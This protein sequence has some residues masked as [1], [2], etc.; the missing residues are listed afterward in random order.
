MI[1][2]NT[3]LVNLNHL[4]LIQIEG[5]ECRKFLQGQLTCD[6]QTLSSEHFTHG[7]H[8]TPKGR[9]IANF[10]AFAL[11]TEAIVLRAPAE[12]LPALLASLK[13]YIVFSKATIADISA[14]YTLVGV[15]GESID[16]VLQELQLNLAEK[17]SA[18]TNDIIFH[19]LDRTR[20]EC[21]IPTS[22]K[23]PEALQ[24]LQ[25]ADTT[26]HWQARDIELGRGWVQQETIEEFL[27]QMLN[28]QT[29]AIQGINFKK[30]CYTG[31]EI[32]AR[33]HYKGKLKR[34]MYRFRCSA[35]SSLNA[36][37]NL[38]QVDRTQPA[39]QVINSVYIDGHCEL[40]ALAPAVQSDSGTDLLV[41]ENS[42]KLE[43]IELPYAITT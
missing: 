39:G 31:Q 35:P 32:V 34:H 7:A 5:I 41:T 26:K 25:A 17:Q 27:P 22:C 2:K 14:E 15:Q 11:K 29:D 6:T 8:C 19:R 33:T 23:V 30:G 36:G 40:L 4:G 18:I 1:M 9:M 38:Y 21:W 43:R 3:Q 10:D 37:A 24:K 12:V 20:L 13:K 28:L 16:S 42:E